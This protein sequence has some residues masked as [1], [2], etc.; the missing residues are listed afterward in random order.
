MKFYLFEREPN[1]EDPGG[2]TVSKKAELSKE[3][4]DIDEHV[5]GD[6]SLWFVRDDEFNDDERQLVYEVFKQSRGLN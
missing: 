3:D 5:W 1:G 6:V 2:I 4:F